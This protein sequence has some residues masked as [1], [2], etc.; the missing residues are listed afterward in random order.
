MEQ[1]SFT[2]DGFTPDHAIQFADTILRAKMGRGLTDVEAI[3]L[4]GAFNRATYE[5]IAAASSYSANYLRQDVGNKFWK[6][7]T[8][9]LGEPVRK[10]NFQVVLC[11]Q[12]QLHLTLEAFPLDVAPSLTL[13]LPDFA[14]PNAGSQA[15][16][17]EETLAPFRQPLAQSTRIHWDPYSAAPDISQFYGRRQELERLSQ[18]LYDDCRLITLF[19]VQGIGKTALAGKLI[20][21]TKNQFE[22]VI[23]RSL[24]AHQPLPLTTLLADLVQII[25][26]QT[27][28]RGTL[29]ELSQALCASACLIVLDGWEAVLQTGVYDGAYRSGYE[30]YGHLLNHLGNTIHQS[31]ILVTSREKPKEV[32]LKERPNGPVRSIELQG[33]KTSAVQSLGQQKDLN[34]SS[35]L[36]WQDLRDYSMG[37]PIALEN[38][39]ARISTLFNGNL[40]AFLKQHPSTLSRD[41]RNLLNQQT[42]RLS[43][44]ERQI[45]HHLAQMPQPTQVHHLLQSL[46]RELDTEQVLEGLQSL[47]RRSLVLQEKTTYGLHPLWIQFLVDPTKP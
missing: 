12:W 25:C 27:H 22:T 13:R 10:R 3:L 30:D 47:R 6:D 4:R 16:A 28:P 8:Q 2:P 26:P 11:K 38:M 21:E 46:P 44:L 1:D 39:A 19:G 40:S 29:V 35:D 17:P 14:M 34:T 18:W 32:E 5:Q 43:D 20:L 33:L 45:L 37:H 42:D 15:I 36:D 23:W 41:F 24:S 9:A 7:L 31:R